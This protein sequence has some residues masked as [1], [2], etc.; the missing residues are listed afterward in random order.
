MIIKRI[1][2]GS[3]FV[4]QFRKLPEPIKK[5]AIKKEKIFWSNPLHPSLRLHGLRGKLSGLFSISLTLNYRIIFTRKP[6]GDIIFASIGK[7]DI[8]NYL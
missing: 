6:N 1:F 4:K 2:Y 5:I 8:Y 7:H 3:D